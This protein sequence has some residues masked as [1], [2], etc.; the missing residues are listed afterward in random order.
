MNRP[1]SEQVPGIE[2]RSSDWKSEVI[3]VIRYL[4]LWLLLGWFRHVNVNEVIKPTNNTGVSLYV[5][6]S[7]QN[8]S[9]Y[10]PKLLNGL[11]PCEPPFI[12]CSTSSLKQNSTAYTPAVYERIELSAHPWQG[13][14]LATTP[15]NQ[16]CQSFLTVTSNPQVWTRI[17][18]SLV[19]SIGKV[20]ATSV[21][22]PILWLTAKCG[23]TDY[24][25]L[26]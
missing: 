6:L 4:Q 10:R 20:T 11:T 22:K 19:G 15:I 26:I 12:V 21:S 1:S 14:M 17:V 5:K 9:F 18:V 25:H 16:N 23:S 2:P 24:Y 8:V 3:T 7:P 13:C